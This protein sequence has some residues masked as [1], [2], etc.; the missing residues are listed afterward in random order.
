[1][2]TSEFQ[3]R[4]KKILPLEACSETA[5]RLD[6]KKETSESIQKEKRQKYPQ[7]E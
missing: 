1:M 2:K 3:A 5:K 7:K 4:M 6:T